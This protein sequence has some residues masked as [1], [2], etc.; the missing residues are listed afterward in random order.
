MAAQ[1]NPL[2]TLELHLAGIP[3]PLPSWETNPNSHERAVI[4][5]C[6]HLQGPTNTLVG[7]ARR[8]LCRI[9][10]QVELP[11]NTKI[12]YMHWGLQIGPYLY[13]LRKQ[14][15]V[16][17]SQRVHVDDAGFWASD[18]PNQEVGTTNMQDQELEALGR[19]PGVNLC[20]REI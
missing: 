8:G 14:G 15:S 1:L 18:V 12:T 16:L 7:L 2:Q 20:S 9:G 5:K 6:R 13:E 10:V 4:W 17:A 11:V 3:A 19:S